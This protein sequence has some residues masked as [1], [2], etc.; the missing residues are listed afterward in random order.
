MRAGYLELH[1][2]GELA[3]R[4]ES[5]LEMLTDCRLCPHECRVD[6]TADAWGR[7]K[8]GRRAAVASAGPHLGEEAPLVGQYGSGTIF[9]AS[10]NLACIFCQN[11]DI[12]QMGQGTPVDA[13]V[14]AEGMVALQDHGCHNINFVTPTHVMPQILEALPEAIEKGL[15]VPIVWNCGGYEGLDSL[16]LLDGIV[17]IYMPDLKYADAATAERLSGAKDYPS[18]AQAA[19]REMHRQVGDLQVN[20]EG[21]AERG[22][23]V[24]HL[25]LPGGLAGTAKLMVFLASLGPDT[26]VNVMPQYRPCHRAFE[27]PKLTRGLTD[28]EHRSALK[29]ARDAGLTRLD[30][31]P[32]RTTI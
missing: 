14:L 10:C 24:R 19:V 6:R 30:E 17:D 32:G 8:T 23:L 15:T 12:S 31:R 1:E 2:S 29:S 25:V 7:C 13:S 4:I 3:R 5:A 11:Y 9:L 28:D 27:E 21:I 22:L 16:R 26:Y 18:H 20:E